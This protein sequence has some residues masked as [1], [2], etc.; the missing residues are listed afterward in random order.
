MNP[1]TKDQTAGP[2]RPN[3]K[4]R[5][6]RLEGRS[7]VPYIMELDHELT[8]VAEYEDA[9]GSRTAAARVRRAVE[10]EAPAKKIARIMARWCTKSVESNPIEN[11]DGLREKYFEEFDALTEK[12]AAKKKSCP[13]CEVGKL[14]RRYR[15]KLKEAG[16][17]DGYE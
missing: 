6:F 4:L 14:M 10:T 2:S 9:K 3:R 5:F 12:F 16:H 13:G 11:T 8:V 1:D 17:F 7:R 15:E